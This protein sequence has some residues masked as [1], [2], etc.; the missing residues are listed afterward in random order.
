M[1]IGDL[2]DKR[3]DILTDLKKKF[4]EIR[5][6]MEKVAT[7]KGYVEDLNM[8]YESCYF[9][10]ENDFDTLEKL[11]IKLINYNT[12][13]S[14]DDFNSE[15][16][17]KFG[18]YNERRNYISSLYEPT[19]EK[20][21]SILRTLDEDIEILSF[22]KTKFLDIDPVPDSYYKDLIELINQFYS[23]EY[24]PVVPIFIRKLIENLLIDILRKRYGRSNPGKFFNTAQRRFHN[25]SI[26][27]ETLE[28][29]LTDFSTI[30]FLNRDFIKQINKFRIQGNSS[31][32]SLELDNYNSIKLDLDES[33]D[34]LNDVIKKLLRAY[35]ILT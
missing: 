8:D 16:R 29:N 31:T 28:N 25:F 11:G 14:L 21:N 30:L 33:K 12:H 22:L 7:G 35:S 3:I 6:I 5:K 32:H 34:E 23:L 1:N 27:L 9:S 2:M 4:S 18:T 19:S 17:G 24:Y 10:I 13:L 20:I 26:L 15:V